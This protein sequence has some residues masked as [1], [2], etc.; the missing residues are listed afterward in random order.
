MDRYASRLIRHLRDCRLDL[1]ISVAGEVA[2]LTLERPDSDSPVRTAGVRRGT[3]AQSSL[4]SESIRYLARYWSYPRRI[5][6]MSCDVVHVLDHSYAHVLTTL[7]DARSVVTVHDMLPLHTVGRRAK[8]V[9]ERIR[10]RLLQRVL[11]ALRTADAWIVST[12]WMRKELAGWLGRDDDIYVIPYGVDDQF[13]ATPQANVR[14]DTRMQWKVPDD[15]FVVLHVGSTGPRKNLEAVIESVARLRAN[16]VN[17]WMVQVGGALSAAQLGELEKLGI[18]EFTVL[19]GEVPE[20]DLR[21][22]YHGADVLLFPSHYEGFGLP[23]IEAMASGLPVITSGEAALSEVGGDAGVV[24]GGRESEP[25]VQALQRVAGDPDW[26]NQLIRRGHKWAKQ[27]SWAEAA[28][29]TADIYGSL[30]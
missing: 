20:P 17:G 21:A 19:V 5:R 9:G 25:Y 14:R 3:Q 26:R 7:P 2:G 10:N 27:F 4:L 24:V 12:N 8:G 29:K 13:F 15:G 1:E 11:N 23:V 22:A 6:Q 30:V 18:T 16:G 28:R